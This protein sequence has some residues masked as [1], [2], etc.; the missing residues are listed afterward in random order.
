MSQDRRP[1]QFRLGSL[2]LAVL[3][4]ALGCLVWQSDPPG[5]AILVT[6]IGLACAPS[7]TIAAAIYFR[8][9]ARAFFIGVTPLLLLY[10]FGGSMWLFFDTL[11]LDNR[12]EFVSFLTMSVQD[13]EALKDYEEEIQTVRGKHQEAVIIFALSVVGGA[14]SVAVRW[15]AQHRHDRK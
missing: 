11:P 2:F 10:L 15:F 13:W 9:Y 7:L 1:W 5:P 6:G 4:V 3:V 14:L 8:G 12:E